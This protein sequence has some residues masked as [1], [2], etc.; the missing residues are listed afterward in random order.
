MSEGIITVQSCKTKGRLSAIFKDSS[1]SFRSLLTR[2][3]LAGGSDPQTN[4]VLSR[5]TFLSISYRARWLSLSSLIS[6]PKEWK[7]IEFY[8]SRVSNS[9][10]RS[11][12]PVRSERASDGCRQIRKWRKREKRQRTGNSQRGMNNHGGHLKVRWYHSVLKKI[13]N[14]F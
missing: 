5:C 4:C 1:I 10:Q 6:L 14:W 2:F 9:S 12:D 13:K 3:R 11:N 8:Q 7:S